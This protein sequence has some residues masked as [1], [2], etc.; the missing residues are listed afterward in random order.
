V[1]LLLTAG[2]CSGY[3]T[4]ST[5]SVDAVTLVEQGDWRRATLHVTLSVVVSL[6]GAAAGIALAREL[7]ALRHGGA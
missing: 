2:F 5:F 4:F 3:T 1:R 7:V 6:A